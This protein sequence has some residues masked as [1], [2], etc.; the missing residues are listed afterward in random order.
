MKLFRN[1]N[2]LGKIEID[3]ILESGYIE[4]LIK[5]DRYSVFPTF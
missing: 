5:D 4:E 2:R 3:G 1:K